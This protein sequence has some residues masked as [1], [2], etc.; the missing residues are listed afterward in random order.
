L[1]HE[2][3]VG[4]VPFTGWINYQL[5]AEIWAMQLWVSLALNKL[6][7]RSL[8]STAP[9]IET[10]LWSAA[11]SS[12]VHCVSLRA[13]CRSGSDARSDLH[14]D[15]RLEGVRAPSD[16]LASA[17]IAD[18]LAVWIETPLWSAATSS[19][20]H[21]TSGPRGTRSTTV[22]VGRLALC[23]PSMLLGGGQWVREARKQKGLNRKSHT[24]QL[25]QVG[26]ATM[27]LAKQ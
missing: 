15:S 16:K 10:P 19:L 5:F 26:C 9:W 27:R 3:L 11:T 1:V 18:Q 21:L 7:C 23:P 14:F 22:R 6:A 17:M 4:P 25:V 12:L 2:E 24:A 20:V 8:Q 13:G